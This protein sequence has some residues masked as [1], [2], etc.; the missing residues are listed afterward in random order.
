MLFINPPW[1][2]ERH[3]QMMNKPSY[4]TLSFN[5]LSHLLVRRIAKQDSI[6]LLWTIAPMLDKAMSLLKIYG[7]YYI[8]NF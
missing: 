2:Y 1:R 4:N 7:F 5:E 3:S 8:T 6:L